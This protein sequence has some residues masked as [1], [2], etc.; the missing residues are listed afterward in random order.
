MIDT[1]AKLRN[2]NCGY[3]PVNISDLESIIDENARRFVLSQYAGF[4]SSGATTTT[5]Y[6][7]ECYG[8]S[9]VSNCDLLLNRQIPW[10]GI[11][12]TS[13]PFAPGQCVGGDTS[14]YTMVVQNISAIHYGIN[15]ESTLTMSRETTCAPIVMDPYRCDDDRGGHGYCHFTYNGKN[16]STLVRMDEANA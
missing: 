7:S 3:W 5:G 16:H 1:L 6:V 14:A 2:V 13:C 10:I 8:A 12:N 15:I 4:V 9:Q 11:E